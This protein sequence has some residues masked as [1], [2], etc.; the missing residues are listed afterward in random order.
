MSS[1]EISPSADRSLKDLVSDLRHHTGLLVRQEIA[2]AKAELKQKAAGV[3]KTAVTF[4]AA[5]LLAYAGVLALLA[6]LA[7]ALVALG[8]VAWL[9][10]LIVA[11]IVLLGAYLLVQRARGTR[12]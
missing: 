8:I 3:A 5:G 6:T 9:A 4:G 11:V 12:R 2:L 10:T 1:V 7:L